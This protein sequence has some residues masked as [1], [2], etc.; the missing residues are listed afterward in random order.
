MLLSTT[1]GIEIDDI[2]NVNNF[3]D[4]DTVKMVVTNLNDKRIGKPE[5]AHR[6]FRR[7]RL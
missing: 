7:P 3:S 4:D 1:E 2:E 6:A 5:T